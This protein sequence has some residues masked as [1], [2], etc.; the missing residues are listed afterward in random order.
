MHVCDEIGN[1]TLATLANLIWLYFSNG[2]GHIAYTIHKRKRHYIKV[3]FT[4]PP[5]PPLTSLMV[6]SITNKSCDMTKLTG[7]FPKMAIFGEDYPNFYENA[8]TMY[9]L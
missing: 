7:S 9:Q 6:L 1:T 3:P 8:L 2:H 5:P 4:P